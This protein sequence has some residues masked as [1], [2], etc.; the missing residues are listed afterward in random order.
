MQQAVPTGGCG[1]R[2]SQ[3]DA[4]ACTPGPV[5]TL[6]VRRCAQAARCLGRRCSFEAAAVRSMCTQGCTRGGQKGGQE[7][8]SSAWQMHIVLPATVTAAGDALHPQ[9]WTRQPASTL[10]TA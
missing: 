9:G 7:A 1:L 8:A 5:R 3:A 6:G 2:S 4:G 10:K